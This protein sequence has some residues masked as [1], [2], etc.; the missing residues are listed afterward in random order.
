M[1]THWVQTLP[2]PLVERSEKEIARNIKK[3]VESIKDVKGYH[4]LSVRMTGKRFY[5]EMHV[6]LDH[7]LRFED[8]HKIASKIEKEVKDI[9]PNARVTIHTEP[10]GVEHEALWTLVKETAE[11]VPG[12][13]G[14][15]NIHI[16]EIDGKLCVDLHL[17]VGANMSVKQ[18]HVVSEQ[19]E[20]R[21]KAAN[22]K[23]SEITIHIESASDRISRELKGVE[24]E[25]ES[26]I[27]DVARRF[28]EI[29][30]VHGIEVRNVDDH[31]HVVLKC[32]L[33]PSI[34]MQQAHE[35]SNTLESEIRSAYPRIARIDV[36]EE[37]A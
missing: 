32:H 36:H 26:Y 34:N 35:I 16:Q 21:I 30:H 5:V 17:E 22:P 11:K 2:L 14:I 29:K 20:N 27:E 15:H 28:P 23:I 33:D 12:S 10:F 8:T 25:L 13:R 1:L 3:K 4:Q 9:V 37:P 24:T 19:V 18:A 31:L 7:N 6:L